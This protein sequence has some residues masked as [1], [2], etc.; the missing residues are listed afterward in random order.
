VHINYP[1]RPARITS[2]RDFVL[3]RLPQP[4]QSSR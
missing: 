1:E 3:A 2:A 4:A